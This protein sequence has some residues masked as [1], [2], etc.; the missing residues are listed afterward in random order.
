MRGILQVVLVVIFFFL[1]VGG[2]ERRKKRG[3]T[4][5][6]RRYRVFQPIWP[7]YLFCVLR[8]HS[9]WNTRCE[10][11]RVSGKNNNCSFLLPPATCKEGRK[12]FFFSPDKLTLHPPQERERGREGERCKNHLSQKQKRKRFSFQEPPPPPPKKKEERIY[13]FF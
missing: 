2:K 13:Y 10:S 1:D 11:E 3:V 4:L 7:Y 6:L 5:C 9:D 8:D 12:D